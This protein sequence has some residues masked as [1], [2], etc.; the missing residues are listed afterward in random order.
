LRWM[1]GL[2]WIRRRLRLQRLRADAVLRRSVRRWM[3]RLRAELRR[4][5]ELQRRMQRLRIG[6]LRVGRL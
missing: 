5:C 3:Q 1:W 6:R 2:R 4:P